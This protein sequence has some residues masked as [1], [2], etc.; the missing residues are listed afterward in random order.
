MN[1]Q[2]KASGPGD[3]VNGRNR[4]RNCA[5]IA[6]PWCIGHHQRTHQPK[7]GGRDKS[8]EGTRGG[9]RGLA[10]GLGTATGVEEAIARFSEAEVLLNN[11][12]IYEA[13]PSEE[14]PDQ[15]WLRVRATLVA[16]C[17]TIEQ[18]ADRLSARWSR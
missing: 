13:K 16:P 14:I 17:E 10:A 5:S 18:L 1:L 8:L 6:T 3:R 9:S 12:D 7:G 11:L 2:R 4:I 15:D